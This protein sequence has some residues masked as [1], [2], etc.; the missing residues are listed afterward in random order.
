MSSA[1][2]RLWLRRRWGVVGALRAG[3]SSQLR[4]SVL[5]DRLMHAAPA[6][7]HGL[8][9]QFRVVQQLD[10][11]KEGIHV[12]VGNAPATRLPGRYRPHARGGRRRRP[13][14]G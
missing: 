12:E 11:G 8:A 9:A 4:L 14:E 2:A 3:S 1:T 13:S 6:D 5:A 10:R 7:H